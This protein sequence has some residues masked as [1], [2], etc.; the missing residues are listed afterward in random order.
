MSPK[1][2]T[3]DNRDSKPADTPEYDGLL[4]LAYYN[5]L[6]PDPGHEKAFF[7]AHRGMTAGN[8][9]ACYVLALM[10]ANGDTPD[11]RTGGKRQMYDHYDAERFMVKATQTD[12]P[13]AGDA[14]L[15]LGEY[16]M[17][18]CRGDDPEEGIEHY[19]AAADMQCDEAVEFLAGYYLEQAQ[20][21]EFEDEE[22]NS[23]LYHY[24]QLAAILNPNDQ[25]YLYGWLCAIGIG[26]PP[27]FHRACE[28]FEEDYAFG[29]REA[30]NALTYLWEKRAGNASLTDK[31]RKR[32]IREA[33]KWR[34]LSKK[35]D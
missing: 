1:K 33:R 7:H 16:F 34:K 10:C 25:N 4:A 23:E 32:C 27:S 13:Y 12:N 15:W 29:H 3:T 22:L 8:G 18:S 14:H 24:Q 35:N 31:E 5:G 2:L 21:A 17:D 9:T 28:C 20:L 6:L 11:Q 19:K 30:A 26:C